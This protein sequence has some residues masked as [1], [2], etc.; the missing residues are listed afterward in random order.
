MRTTAN[1]VPTRVGIHVFSLMSGSAGDADQ[2]RTRQSHWLSI[3]CGA[4]QPVGLSSCP[5]HHMEIESQIRLPRIPYLSAYNPPGMR[6][7][8]C[9][10]EPGSVT[11]SS[12]TER[13][14]SPDTHNP[15][16]GQREDERG[17]DT[18]WGLQ[19]RLAGATTSPLAVRPRRRHRPSKHA[20]PVRASATR[21]PGLSS[22]GRS[23]R[24]RR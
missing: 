19:R 5:P 21:S 12:R 9:T 13:R 2:C 18:A 4:D 17:Q 20:T 8:S 10:P 16:T 24:N 1:E 15:S 6:C 11:L 3:P 7:E 14:P 23:Y 22:P